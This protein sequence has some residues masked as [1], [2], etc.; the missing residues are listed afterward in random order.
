MKPKIEI[1]L[2]KENVTVGILGGHI[3]EGGSKY[4]VL[5]SCIKSLMKA[6]Q[7]AG[8]KVYSVKECIEKSIPMHFTIGLN[9]SDYNLWGKLLEAKLPVIMWNV[10]SIFYQNMQGLDQHGENPYFTL[11]TVTPC[12][13]EAL[14]EYYPTLQHAYMPGA[15]DLDFWKKQNCAKDIDIVYFSSLF[16]Y[17]Q[18]LL[19]IKNRVEPAFF[20]LMMEIYEMAL[21]N[22]KVSFWEITKIIENNRG[23]RFNKYGYH[24]IFR[25]LIYII[26]YAKRIALVQSLSKFNLKIYGDAVWQK[27]ISGNIEYM[28]QVDYYDSVNIMNRAKIV[29]HSQPRQLCL[30]IN[31]RVMNASAIETFTLASDVKTLETHFGDN[32]GYYNSTTFEDIGDKVNYFL[33]HEDERISKAKNARK[34]VEENHTITHRAAKIISMLGIK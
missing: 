28:G 27:Y 1:K 16:D 14:S 22:P 9:G 30:G 15:I 31:E 6:F 7:L 2:K 20:D 5:N 32:L 24:S 34:I 29:L 12:D 23:A 26:D 18:R 25:D 33:T 4:N 13:K 8:V 3:E 11:L 10:D 19:E 17:E 21:A